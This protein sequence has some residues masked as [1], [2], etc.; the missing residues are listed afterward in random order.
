V[1]VV[2]EV[3]FFLLLVLTFIHFGDE[4]SCRKI[5]GNFF[6]SFFVASKNFFV[7]FDNFVESGKIRAKTREFCINL[8]N[9][10]K[11]KE[12]LKIK[13]S[14]GLQNYQKDPYSRRKIP[15]LKKINKRKIL[16]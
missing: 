1:V 12:S 3:K 8:E 2:G 14:L 6:S 16:N 4:K 15:N 13:I 10:V 7:K 9:Y 11:G 5:V